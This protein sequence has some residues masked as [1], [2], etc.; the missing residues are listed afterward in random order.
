MESSTISV[1]GKEPSTFVSKGDTRTHLVCRD[2]PI[3]TLQT[4]LAEFID[5]LEVSLK[6]VQSTISDYSLDEIEVS[7]EVSAAGSI[8]LVGSIEAGATG[9]ITLKFKRCSH[10]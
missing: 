6:N 4:N 7:I 3:D 5:K 10:E 9:G 1:V 2:L 8:S